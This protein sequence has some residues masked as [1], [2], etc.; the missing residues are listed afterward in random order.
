[1]LMNHYGLGVMAQGESASVAGLVGGAQQTMQH[2]GI[3]WGKLPQNNRR[4]VI[5]D[6]VSGLREEDIAKLS[7]IRSS[8][9]ATVDKIVSQKTEAKTRILWLS[10][11]RDTRTVNQFSSGIDCIE[12][13]TRIKEDIAR[14]DMAII[15]GKDDVPLSEMRH[16]S[17]QAVPHVFTGALCRNLILWAWTR[18][19]DEVMILSET[20]DAAFELGAALSKKYSSDFT[21]VVAPEQPLKLA[22]LATALAGRLYS[23]CDGHHLIVEPGHVEYIFQ[24]LDRVYSSENFGYDAWSM[25]RN[26]GQELVDIQEIQRFMVRATPLGCLKLSEA[27]KVTLRDIEELL[28]ISIDEAKAQLSRLILNNALIRY[29]QN[30]YRKT[31]QFN[32]MLRDYAQHNA[33]NL[34][35]EDGL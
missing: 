15:I 27:S 34:H 5:I 26:Q 20:E 35:N 11:P 9:E 32:R 2:W 25:A 31:P 4:L 7:S 24:Y 28:G 22:R 3:T 30:Y 29:Y 17:Q 1:M 16:L 12:S 14:W 23:T 6:E 8:G 18:T 10:N 33:V 19:V 21:L 13:L